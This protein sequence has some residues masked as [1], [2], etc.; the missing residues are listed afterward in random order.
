MEVPILLDEWHIELE[1]P[2]GLEDISIAEVE[3]KLRQV[4]PKLARSGII[5]F[6]YG[7][8]LRELTNLRSVYACYIVLDFAIPRP[9]AFLG[10]QYFTQITDVCKQILKTAHFHTININA[11]GSDSSVMQRI[12]VEMSQALSL[13]PDPNDGD[14]LIRIR[15]MRDIWQVVIRTTPRPLSTREWR[16]HD[17]QGALNA[18]TAYAMNQLISA[19]YDASRYANFMCGSGTILIERHIQNAHNI[20]YGLDISTQVLNMARENVAKAN[21]S[22]IQLIQADVSQSP[23][24]GNSLSAITSDMPFGQLVGSHAE[25]KIIYPQVLREMYRVLG[26]NGVAV[27][28]THEVRLFEQIIQSQNWNVKQIRKV[29]LRGLHPRIYVLE[30]Q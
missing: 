5:T 27:L 25:N 11:A 24:D 10:H 6:D 12:L 1:V 3:Q 13:V 2:E 8:H 22:H 26:K 21:K 28:I 23:F 15:K 20:I 14:L 9:K 18:P 30:K 4:K 29:N 19:N 7:D 17:Y 16:I